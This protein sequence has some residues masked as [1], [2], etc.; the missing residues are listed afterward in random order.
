MQTV[1]KIGRKSD[2]AIKVP[3]NDRFLTQIFQEYCPWDHRKNWFL[4][5]GL[6]HVDA[7]LHE[8]SK[9][10][11]NFP[12]FSRKSGRKW[13][14]VARLGDMS[15]RSKMWKLVINQCYTVR[16]NDHMCAF[17]YETSDKNSE[18]CGHVTVAKISKNREKI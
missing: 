15:M 8:D 4:I 10:D 6:V 13:R 1:A 12:N 16:Q 18:L 5:F 17:G 7:K 3:E 14:L 11:L 2:F 9:Y